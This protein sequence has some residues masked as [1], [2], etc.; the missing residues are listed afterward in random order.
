M[1]VPTTN[2]GALPADLAKDA[3]EYLRLNNCGEPVGFRAVSESGPNCTAGCLAPGSSPHSH[4][5]ITAWELIGTTG[6]VFV[7]TAEHPSDRVSAGDVYRA[8]TIHPFPAT[9]GAA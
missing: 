7:A 9:D 5:I 8:N 1:T 4:S 3:A 6:A 2:L